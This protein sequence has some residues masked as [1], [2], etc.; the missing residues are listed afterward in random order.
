MNHRENKKI[1]SITGGLMWTFLERITAQLVSTIVGI[2]LARLLDPEHYGIISIVMVFITFFN[3]FVTS[4]FS[5]AI[6]QKKEVDEVDYN[7]SFYIGL[8]IS[9]IAYVCLFLAAPMI[10]A[11]YKYDV[12]MDV[13]RVMGLRLPLAALNSTQQA[14]VRRN[15]QFK[16]FFVVTLFGTVVSG[17][18][19]IILAVEG[20]GVWALVAQYLT[21]TTIDSVMMFLMCGWR[22]KIQFSV[23]KAKQIFSFGWKILLSDMIA[24]LETDIRSL[25]VGKTFGGAKLAFYDQGKKYPGLLVN[26]VN[27]AINKVMLPAYSKSQENLTELKSMLRKSIKVGVYVLAPLLI[28]FSAVAENFILVILTEKWLYSIPYIHVFCMYFLTRPMETS[29]QQA[30]LAIGRSDIVMRI[31]IAINSIS[32]GTL[33][34]AAFVMKSVFAVA[35][36]SLIATFV[37]FSCYL[38]STNKLIGYKLKEQITD[39]APIVFVAG[40]MGGVVKLI[41][42]LPFAAIIVLVFQILIGAI[43]YYTLSEILK[44]EAHVYLRKILIKR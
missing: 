6:V 5:T 21:N 28:G 3:V 41:G 30:I 19:G 43:V 27:S 40:I 7:T 14:Y 35:L 11:F 8:S 33:L 26:N 2:V 25:V 39:I 13:L 16:K 36:G 20:F 29:C 23:M 32:L 10:A 37:S 42:L 12:L 24:T 22:P 1:K 44:I 9:I 18:V 34:F 31:M 4:G 17:I 38:F 15:M